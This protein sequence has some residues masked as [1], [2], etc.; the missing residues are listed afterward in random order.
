VLQADK[1]YKRYLD[2]DRKSYNSV[3]FNA[4]IWMQVF[5]QINA[6]KI[7]DELNV[8]AGLWKSKAFM[9]ILVCTQRLYDFLGFCSSECPWP[10][11]ITSNI[12]CF[13]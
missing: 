9:Y 1:Q 10:T 2:E 6:R 5:N 11:C 13:L 12:E 3:V 4:F 7:D 8:F